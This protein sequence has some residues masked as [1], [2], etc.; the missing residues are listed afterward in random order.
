V[1]VVAQMQF[2]LEKTMSFH[3]KNSKPIEVDL[4]RLKRVA[5]AK[6]VK[7][8]EKVRTTQTNQARRVVAKA[9]RKKA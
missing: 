6:R 9:E 8:Q 1:E 2:D 4:L 3:K 7:S 5:N